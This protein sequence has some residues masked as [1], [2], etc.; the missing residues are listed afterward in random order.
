VRGIRSN[1]RI[2][3]L[4]Q[5]T[6]KLRRHVASI[7]SSGSLIL[8]RACLRISGWRLSRSR[9]R[10]SSKLSSID[11]V[12][13]L[14]GSRR[15]DRSEV[16]IEP[17]RALVIRA[18]IL[19]LLVMVQ[20]LN[21]RELRR[22]S[23]ST[24]IGLLVRLLLHSSECLLK[25]ILVLGL[26]SLVSLASKELIERQVL[27]LLLVSGGGRRKCSWGLLDRSSSSN[28]DRIEGCRNFVERRTSRRT[29]E[30]GCPAVIA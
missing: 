11:G 28:R 20:L 1:G 5:Q 3:T 13:G 30:S 8:R 23:R 6:V 22:S 14:L 16:I 27:Y 21:R 24:T 12:S 19:L 15:R 25:I 9:N 4:G 10:E 2:S 17:Q 29:L 18:L 7:S 26:G